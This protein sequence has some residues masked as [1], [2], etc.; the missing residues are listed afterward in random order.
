MSEPG[1]KMEEKLQE[2]REE[3]LKEKRDFESLLAN[4]GWI[5]LSQMFTER[6]NEMATVLLKSPL[7]KAEGVYCQEFDKGKITGFSEVLGYPEL[8]I[9]N[10]IEMKE[11]IDE[12]PHAKDE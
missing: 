4:P 10:A 2:E 8:V 12:R 3:A 6:L 5:R 11:A 1:E 7:L 9:G